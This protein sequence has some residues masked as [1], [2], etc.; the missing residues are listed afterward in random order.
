M[1]ADS[2]D[3]R[4]SRSCSALTASPTSTGVAASV[5]GPRA[6]RRPQLGERV[7]ELQEVLENARRRPPDEVLLDDVGIGLEGDPAAFQPRAGPARSKGL[8]RQLEHSIDLAGRRA[9]GQPR[10]DQAD[11]R[12]DDVTSREGRG[13]RELPEQVHLAAR[14]PDLLFGLAQRGVPQVGILGVAPATGKRDLPGMP[15][16]VGAAPGQD[17]M[18]LLL[19]GRHEQRHEHPG[20]GLGRGGVLVCHRGLGD[21]AGQPTAQATR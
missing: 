13:R 11:E 6:G 19:A 4:R 16:Q 8:Q 14:Q 12:V 21:G 5:R 7:S 1:T 9:P 18:E 10:R 2:R 17:D 15:A 20:R 3:R